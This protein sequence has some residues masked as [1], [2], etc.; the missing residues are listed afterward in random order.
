MNN[1]NIKFLKKF[2]KPFGK[3]KQ[4]G[5]RIS[6]KSS[7]VKYDYAIKSLVYGKITSNEIE[8]ARRA[9]RKITKK[10]GKVF[11]RI[12]PYLPLTKKPAEVRMGKGKGSKIRNWVYPIKP[13]KT[14]FE[15]SGVTKSLSLLA[16]EK[17]K[18][19]LSV[20]CKIVDLG[21]F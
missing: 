3:V 18:E 6:F 14:L 8:S 13:G 21:K 10:V 15:I 7:V 2:K 1:F 19:K 4:N 5:F 12:Y 11:I 16:L 20:K 17:A 9:I